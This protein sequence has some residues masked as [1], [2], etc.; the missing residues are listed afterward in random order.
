MSVWCLFIGLVISDSML[1]FVLEKEIRTCVFYLADGLFTTELP[2]KP[3]FSYETP[4]LLGLWILFLYPTTH[5][6]TIVYM[7]KDTF[8]AKETS[9]F[10]FSYRVPDVYFFPMGKFVCIS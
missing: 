9:R 10:S 8:G 6:K 3:Y 4:H 1:V 7:S 2:G 5:I